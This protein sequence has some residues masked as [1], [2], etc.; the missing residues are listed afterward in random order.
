[1]LLGR[2]GQ[3]RSCLSRL[4]ETRWLALGLQVDRVVPAAA[5]VAGPLRRPQRVAL[6][7]ALPHRVGKHPAQHGQLVL[8][9]RLL[10][11]GRL[12]VG[13]VLRDARVVDRRQR[14]RAE[15]RLEVVPP[16]T[17]VVVERVRRH[18]ADLDLAGDALEP[19]AG[20]LAQRDD[21]PDR[22]R[23]ALDDE[24]AQIGEIALEL[25]QV[26]AA[27]PDRQPTEV[28]RDAPDATLDRRR[29]PARL[30]VRAPAAGGR[31]AAARV[32][33]SQRPAHQRA[34]RSGEAARPRPS[35]S[36]S[37]PAPG[38]P[39]GSPARTAPRRSRR[40]AR[41]SAPAP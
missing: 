1:M 40:T 29:A 2:R 16:T 23:P 8:D 5:T 30:G 14:Q 37:P 31:R 27:P 13:H 24:Q 20:E 21:P 12:A 36:A 17:L 34:I 35:A 11:T 33:D 22:R 26:A 18:A 32:P 25:D 38:R 7:E 39:R 41:T 28:A 10:Q 4:E 9:R 3:Q 6:D 15:E 19:R